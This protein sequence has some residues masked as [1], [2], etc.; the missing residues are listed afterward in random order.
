MA[1]FKYFKYADALPTST[2]LMPSETVKEV[3]EEVKKKKLKD[4][5]RGQYQKLSGEDKAAIAKYALENG[6]A[7]TLR[8]FKAKNLKATSVSDWRKTYE[9][10]LKEKKSWERLR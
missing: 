1:L 5:K 10:V 3:S 9:G 6:I 4:G 8:H 2:P 7:N